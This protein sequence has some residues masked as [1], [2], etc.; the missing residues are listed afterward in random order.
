[1]TTLTTSSGIVVVSD[2]VVAIGGVEVAVI[3]GIV[4]HRR[5]C[6]WTFGPWYS[7]EGGD[8]LE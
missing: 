6:F 5:C 2:V 7:E 1:M 8:S 4:F 3:V